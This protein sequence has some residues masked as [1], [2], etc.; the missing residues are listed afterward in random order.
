MK[1]AI[2]KAQHGDADEIDVLFRL[3]RLPF[4]EQPEH[5]AYAAEPPASARQI[6][7]SCS[8]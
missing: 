8:S 2:E 4:D 6:E 5:E 1:A 3:L 7:V